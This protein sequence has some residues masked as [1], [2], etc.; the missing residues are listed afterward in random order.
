MLEF[1]PTLILPT[2]STSSTSVMMTRAAWVEVPRPSESEGGIAASPRYFTYEFHSEILPEDRRVIVYVPESYLGDET[3]RFPVFYLQDGQNLFDG[4]TSYV[5]GSTWDAH[6][7]A[8]RLTAEGLIEP[9]LL[10]GVYNTGIRRMPE[11]TPTRDPRLVGGEGATYG[12]VLVEEIKPL[13]DQHFRTRDGRE[14]TAVGGSSLGGL[15]SLYFGLI[16]PEIFGKAAVLSPSI[17]WDGR[18]VLSLVQQAEPRPEL[19]IW[20]DMGMAEGERHL[21]DADLLDRMLRRRG[22]RP[23]LD[24]IYLRVPGGVHDENAWSARFDRVLRFL[25]PRRSATGE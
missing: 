1:E 16:Y 24:L 22:W 21:H 11:Y 17:W 4:K 7:T 18:S 19:Q 5:A 8:D 15:I 20:L 23:G 14:H 3:R 12:R 2:E 9:I 13:V 25:F 6:T 10:V